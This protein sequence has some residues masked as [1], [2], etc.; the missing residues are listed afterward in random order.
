MLGAVLAVLVAGP[1]IYWYAG[2]RRS[3]ELVMYG[4]VD[5]RQVSLGFR[6]S[7]RLKSL[8]FDEGDAVPAGA[9]MARLDPEPYQHAL[10]QARAN[11]A[12]LKARAD[13]M[14][15]GYRAEEVAQ[16]GATLAQRQAALADAEAMLR[17]QTELKGTGATSGRAYDDALSARDQAAAQARAAA[18]QLALMRRGYR[19]EDRASANAQL[20]Q[21]MAAVASA[22]LQLNDT[23]LRA[24]EGGVVLTRAAEAGAVLAAGATL[25]TVSLTQPVWVRAYVAEPDLGRVAPGSAV[26]VYTDGRPDRPYAG[27]VGYVS[28]SAEFTPKN[29][30]TPDLRTDLVY[31][32]RIVIS[33][34]DSG[35]RQGMPVTVKLGARG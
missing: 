34:A 7:G 27:T 23:V 11:A 25:F 8:S 19:K 3:D 24:P 16:A 29:V 4:N 5:I 32:L 22:R 13:Q 10:D 9:V 20:A 12:V 6:V 2:S 18:E 26:R 28:P 33:N 1:A 31:R 30:E 14:Q 17:R 35:L 15:A 21:A